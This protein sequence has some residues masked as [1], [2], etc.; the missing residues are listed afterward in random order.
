MRRVLIV[1]GA[2]ALLGTLLPALGL[3][4]WTAALGA[5]AAAVVAP[6]LLLTQLLLGEGESPP[7]PLEWGIFPVA[8]GFVLLTLLTLGLSLLP[9]G[10]AL[11]QVQV[12]FGLLAL[13]LAAA[14]LLRAR[15]RVQYAPSPALADVQVAGRQFWAVTAALLALGL[16]AGLLR[17]SQ[18]GYSEFHGDEARAVLRAAAVLQGHEN[19]L[20]IHRKPPGEILATLVVFA[21]GGRLNEAAARLPF[22]LANLA[23]LLGV[24]LLGWRIRGQAAGWA[25]ALLLALDGYLVAFAHFVQYQSVV[26]LLSVTAVLTFHRLY[27][28]PRALGRDLTA[29]ALCLA[30]ALLFHWD[31]ALALLPAAA[32]LLALWAEGRVRWATLWRAALPAALVGS[33]ALALFFV[34]WLLRPS[35]EAAASYLLEARLLGDSFGLRNNLADIVAR[36]TVYSSIYGLASYALLGSAALLLAWRRG[37]SKRAGVAAALLLLLL[38]ATLWRPNLLNVGG[39]D[40]TPLLWLLLLGGLWPAPH[41]RNDERALW[42]W[43]GV[44]LLASLFV[45]AT[46]RTH[47]HIFLVPWALV[48]GLAVEAAWRRLGAWAGPRVATGVAL[49]A[50][51]LPTVLIGGWLWLAFVNAPAAVVMNWETRKPALY[52]TPAAAATIDGKYGFPLQNGWKTVG[53]LYADGTLRGDYDALLW[54]DSVSD[55][56]LRGRNRCLSTS[57]WYLTVR[58][59]DPWAERPE[60]VYGRIESMGFSTWADVPVNQRAAMR[61]FARDRVTAA[62]PAQLDPAAFSAAFDAAADPWLPLHYPTLE[63]AAPNALEANFGD[64]ITLEGYALEYDAPLRAGDALTLTLYWRARSAMEVGYKVSNQIYD[65]RGNFAVQKDSAPLCDRRPT[66]RWRPGEAVVDRHTLPISAD[67]PPGL[68]PLYTALYD[69]VTGARLPVLDAAGAPIDDKVRIAEIEVFAP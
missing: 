30:G 19:V 27:R 6:G 52:W 48:A 60:D 12:A 40:L 16:L 29:G 18:L 44:P 63:E 55:W 20:Y 24:L 47:V 36:T 37:W 3:P 57:D 38:A 34:P 62:L 67:T 10:L 43:L 21:W 23:A 9:G 53:A 69:P 41:L 56:Y 66:D 22:A 5:F 39:V 46:P 17:L 49:G 51:A 32:L 31:G 14:V 58:T 15:G 59:L 61:I 64:R 7:T 26:L 68:Y 45:I 2:A 28:E 42:L 33:A 11:W 25:A 65:D 54:A 1:A 4:L 35:A 50:A 8:L 13:L